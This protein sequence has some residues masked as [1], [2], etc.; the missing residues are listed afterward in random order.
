[1]YTF[2]QIKRIWNEPVLLAMIVLV[3][4]LLVIFVIYPIAMVF[5]K[6]LQ[7]T[8]E[9]F[10]LSVY[11]ALFTKK[12]FRVPFFNSLK[13]GVSVASV[14]VL[15]GYIFAYAITRV[16]I[17]GK[18]FFRTAASFPIISPP[19]VIALAAILLFGRNGFITHQIFKDKLNIEIYGFWGLLVV[20]T[21]A[22][23]PTAFMTLEGILQSIDPALE[24]AS[25]S[26]KAS[27]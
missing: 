21:L 10:D 12:Y 13:L 8:G 7:P 9:G 18:A 15:V 17:P 23:F 26:L 24:E 1:M 19:F 27:K 25:L 2:K 4:V 16:N 22:Y 5:L 3:V 6:S 11:K 20:E 14:G